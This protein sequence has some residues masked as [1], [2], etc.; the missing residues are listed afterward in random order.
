[1][2]RPRARS[3]ADAQRT[4]A[5]TP[6]LD[7]RRS[8]RL[9]TLGPDWLPLVLLV[10]DAIIVVP[11]ILAAYR[12]HRTVDPFHTEGRF[13]PFGPY[14]VAIPIVVVRYLFALTI[15]RHCQSLR[16]RSL[17]DLLLGL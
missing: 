7:A 9:A 17:A 10:G 1:M 8:S 14:I 4:A 5:P 13:L 16:G 3:D 11:S 12:F 6:E 15:N 2:A